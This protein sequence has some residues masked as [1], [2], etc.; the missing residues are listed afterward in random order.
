M[1]QLGD[2]EGKAPLVWPFGHDDRK[3]FAP[4][5][6]SK[7]GPYSSKMQMSVGRRVNVHL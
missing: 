3:T 2:L 6:S 7:P 1:V 4:I 5:R